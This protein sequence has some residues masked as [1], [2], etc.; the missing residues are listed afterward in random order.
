MLKLKEITQSLIKLKASV[1]VDFNFQRI[2]DLY[3][4]KFLKRINNRKAT[5]FDFIPPQLVKVSAYFLPKP[6]TIAINNNLKNGIFPDEVKNT[7]VVPRET[8]KNRNF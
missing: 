3:V 6:L 7:T 4:L 2:S 1:P 8:E 5:G